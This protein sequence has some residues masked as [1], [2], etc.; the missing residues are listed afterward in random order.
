MDEFLVWK[1]W[2]TQ[3]YR[4]EIGEG[5]RYFSMKTA[6]NI[7]HQRKGLNIVE[8]GTIRALNDAAGGGNSTVLFGDYAQV[9]DKKFWTVDILPEAIA[10]SKTVTEG[11]NKNTTLLVS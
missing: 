2:W 7:F 6:L 11:Y 3:K 9:Y 5:V 8:T 4:F 1:D 10:L